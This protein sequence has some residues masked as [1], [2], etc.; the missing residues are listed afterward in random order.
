MALV[1][2][3]QMVAEPVCEIDSD[4]LDAV[5]VAAGPVTVL[6]LVPLHPGRHQFK[7]CRR[8]VQ[9]DRADQNVGDPVG[10]QEQRYQCVFEQRIVPRRLQFDFQLH[11]QDVEQERADEEQE[12]DFEVVD[13]FE[14]LASASVLSLLPLLDPK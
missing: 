7:R 5:H 6:A 10:D 14:P 9:E 8:R 2:T 1:V 13:H 4:A 3:V 12:C 11:D